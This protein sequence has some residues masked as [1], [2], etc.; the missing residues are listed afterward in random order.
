MANKITF[1]EI[2]KKISFNFFLK[3][4]SSAQIEGQWMT[5]S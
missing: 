3:F 2:F 1:S 4:Q 5:D